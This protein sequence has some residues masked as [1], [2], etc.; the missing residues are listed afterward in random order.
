MAAGGDG[1]TRRQEEAKRDAEPPKQAGDDEPV[2]KRPDAR[3]DAARAHNGRSRKA[4]R[5]WEA[6]HT[7]LCPSCKP[8][9]TNSQHLQS[10][11][12]TRRTRT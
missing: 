12:K 5:H 7:S 2:P 3:T 10:Q 11:D 1:Q 9:T 8:H 4:P 6:G